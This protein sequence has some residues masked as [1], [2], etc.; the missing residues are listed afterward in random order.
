MFLKSIDRISPPITLYYKQSMAHTSIFS[1]IL[2][3]L[4]YLLCLASGIYFSMELILKTNPAAYFYNR[5]VLDSGTFYMNTTGMF[6]YLQ[7]IG[8]EIYNETIDFKAVTI[9]GFSVEL[10]EYLQNPNLKDY[11]YWIYDHCSFSDLRHHKNLVSNDSNFE[12][13]ACIRKHYNHITKRYSNT[14]QNNF[15]YPRISKGHANEH[16]E[17]YG[18]ILFRC[19]ND[20]ERNESCYSTEK[21]TKYMSHIPTLALHVLD[22]YADVKNFK[23]PFTN[24]FYKITNGMFNL[25]FTTNHLNFLPFNILTHNGFIFDESYESLSYSFEQN[26]KI[27]YDTLNSG[28]LCSFYFWMS[29]RMQMYERTYKKFQDINANVGG[30]ITTLQ[31]IASIINFFYNKYT[32]IHDTIDILDNVSYSPI[33]KCSNEKNNPTNNNNNQN[34][35][36]NGTSSYFVQPFSIKKQ[37]FVYKAINNNFYNNHKPISVMLKNHCKIN[38]WSVIMSFFRKKRPKPVERMIQIMHE[39]RT[40]L[41]SE[42]QLVCCYFYNEKARKEIEKSRES[43]NLNAI[44]KDGYDSRGKNT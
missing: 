8:D 26:E 36:I 3:I 30:M 20:I 10:Y 2:T 15:T 37:L 25:T 21:I 18:L 28:I 39:F 33:S 42:E 4:V 32:T 11:D 14:S 16:R 27:T 19:R 7:F 13:S 12:G 17:N 41:V 5:Y 24:E 43:T 9:L 23:N 29:N 1:G 35:S 44:F 6:H 40:K 22:H 31:I 34:L 38:I